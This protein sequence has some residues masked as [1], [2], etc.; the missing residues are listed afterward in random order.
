MKIGSSKH[1][2]LNPDAEFVA[3]LRRRIK[4]NG[5]Y[6]PCKYDKKPENK[7]P[8]Q[9]FRQHRDCDCGLYLKEEETNE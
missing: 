4:Q 5:G 3:N 6:C 8:C 2:K 1:G 9:D 7:C